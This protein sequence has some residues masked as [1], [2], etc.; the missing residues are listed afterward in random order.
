LKRK[1]HEELNRLKSMKKEEILEK[2]KKAEFIS[3][4]NPNELES[5]NLLKKAEKE[6]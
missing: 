3:G 1:K 5:R 6:L 2:L 4:Y